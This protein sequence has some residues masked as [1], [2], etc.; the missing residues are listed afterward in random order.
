MNETAQHV[1]PT[2][3]RGPQVTD[4]WRWVADRRAKREPAIAPGLVVVPDVGPEGALKMLSPEDESP[5][6]AF[7]PKRPHP[8]FAEGV[9]VRGPDRSEDDPPAFGPEHLIEGAGELGVPVV[10]QE[11]RGP[12][13][14]LQSHGEVPGLLGDPSRVGV[15]R[16][17]SQANPS[18]PE[19]D[20][21]QDIERLQPDG[22]NSEEVACEH[23][24]RLLVKELFPRGAAP[25]SRT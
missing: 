24:G 25:R 17:S 23:P 13:L 18:R 14:I 19:L 8:S 2:N 7:S 16:R 22:L 21:Y 4:G 10:D 11:P 20:P 1:P 3:I 9:G 6:Q 15:G 12:S 5:I